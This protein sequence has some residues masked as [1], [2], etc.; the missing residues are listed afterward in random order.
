M[1]KA[2]VLI[3]FAFI[4]ASAFAQFDSLILE[5]NYYNSNIFIYNPDVDNSYSIQ[6]ITV[7]DDSLK[8]DLSTNG[9]ELD[10]SVLKLKETSPIR[11]KII[12]ESG[13]KPT[14]V[15][16]EVLVSDQKLR[17]SRPKL[18]KGN[19]QWR[20]NGSLSDSPIIIEYFE[21]GEWR[22]IGEVD[23][24]DTIRNSLYQFELQSHSGAN[25][26]RLYTY[27]GQKRKVVSKELRYNVSKSFE[28]TLAS[29]KIKD[30][31]VFSRETHYELYDI[32][33]V[34]IKSGVDRYVDMR[35]LASGLYWLNYDNFTIQ[36]K[37][38]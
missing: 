9:I 11:I 15:N 23:P 2:I 14:I 38:K 13:F 34:L 35:G 18:I 4:H 36:I 10:F 37:K 26:V 22:I 12:Y 30:D 24:L 8:G 17:F 21:W 29:T 33:G 25:K 31:V 16:P 27:D 7:N 1:N 28:V 19:L 5:G 32:E 6:S 3:V 20:L